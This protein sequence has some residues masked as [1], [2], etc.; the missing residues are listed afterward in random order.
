[1][2]N[3]QILNW[4][5][6]FVTVKTNIREILCN[7]SVIRNSD[8]G[9]SLLDYLELFIYCS[10]LYSSQR[11]SMIWSTERKKEFYRLA[12]LRLLKGLF[13]LVEACEDRNAPALLPRHVRNAILLVLRPAESAAR[14]LIVVEANGMEIPD[15]TPPPKREKSARTGS[16]KKRGKRKPRFRLIDP[17]KSLEEFHPNRRKSKPQQ[18][19]STERQV[20]VRVASFDGQPDFVIWSEPKAPPAADDLINAAAILR[21]MEALQGAL[22]DLPAQAKRM[23]REMAKRKAAAPGPKSVPPLR[24]GFPPGYRQRPVHAVDTIL[25]ECS[26]LARRI[27]APDTS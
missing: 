4:H 23:V 2:R 25:R 11:N 7:L 12:L 9:V 3:P 24:Y 15:Y 18:K 5:V 1:M 26:A 10:N 21:R 16:G 20:Q 13:A 14:R 8:T 22:Q 19:A 27:N 6:M 17:R